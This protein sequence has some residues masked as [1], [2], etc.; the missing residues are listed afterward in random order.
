MTV[1]GE[2][3]RAQTLDDV[4][5]SRV[6]EREREKRGIQAT[7]TQTVRNCSVKEEKEREETETGK[8]LTPQ[9]HFGGNKWKVA[10]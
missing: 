7:K 8:Q 2:E 1:E 9:A 5:D 3:R 6:R 10:L 4:Y